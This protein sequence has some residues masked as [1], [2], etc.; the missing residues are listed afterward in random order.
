MIFNQYKTPFIDTLSN[1]SHFLCTSRNLLNEKRI[2]LSKLLYF[3]T[4]LVGYFI[5]DFILEF[6]WNLIFCLCIYIMYGI[7][8]PRSPPQGGNYLNKVGKGDPY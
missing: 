4:K 1:K 5:D 8:T 2:Y 7:Y 3:P 6:G